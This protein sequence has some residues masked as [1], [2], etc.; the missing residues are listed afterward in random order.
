MGTEMSGT[1]E[2]SNKG[3]AKTNHRNHFNTPIIFMVQEEKTFFNN[4]NLKF[5]LM[6]YIHFHDLY[7]YCIRFVVIYIFK[8]H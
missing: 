1:A 4:A 3:K 8:W 7:N 2:I 5:Y 6:M